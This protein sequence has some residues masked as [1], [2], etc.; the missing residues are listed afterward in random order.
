MGEIRIKSE[1]TAVYH[2]FARVVHKRRLLDE[3]EREVWVRALAR[4]ARFSGV[5]VITYCCLGNHFHILVRID[6]AARDCS[7]AELVERFAALYGTS[8]AAWCGLDAAGLAHALGQ[9]ETPEARRLRGRLR[10]RMGDVSEF[11]RT[12][13][14][15]Y[16]KWYNRTHQTAG[17]L[18]SE[19]FGSVLVQ[20][21]PWLVALVAAYVDLN[22]V[23]AG[24]S[25][26][27]GEYRWSGYTAA[28]AGNDELR[29]SLAACFPRETDSDA[30]L[31]CYRRL[32][33][34][35]GAAAKQDGTGARVDPEALL[36]V[37]QTGGELPPHELLRLKLRFLTQGRA[38]GTDAW[39]RQ[40]TAAGRTDRVP[41]ST[42]PLEVLDT[43]EIAVGCRKYRSG[44][45]CMP[46][47]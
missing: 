4:A 39:M 36:E 17:T 12:L 16:T 26:L 11:M 46:D 1:K 35:K 38:L 28:L 34:G 25:A 20:D 44:G 18:W 15:R 31:A 8:R 24:L 37:V 43:A 41:L 27:P 10:A 7:D 9:G 42:A 40:V 21:I 3:V 45:V 14:Q 5:E 6:P 2:V 32:M 13:R 23:R 30:S 47:A 22:P 29:H 19:R 33:L